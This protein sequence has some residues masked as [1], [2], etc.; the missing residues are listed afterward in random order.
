MGCC[1]ATAGSIPRPSAA[2]GALNRFDLIG[3]KLDYRTAPATALRCVRELRAA[4]R[5]GDVRIV[6]F[7]GDDDPNV[8][9]PALIE[10]VDGYVKKHVFADP[11]AYARTYRGKSNLTDHLVRTQ[12]L[13]LE[14][15]AVQTS[16]PL[17]AGAVGKI[18]LGWNIALDDK[19]HDLYRGL[20][21]PRLDGRTVDIA[22]RAYVPPTLWT[23][24]LR[25]PVVEQ[26]ERLATEL[27]VLAPRDR[28]DQARYYR[29]MLDAKLCVSPFGYGEICW[30]DFEAILCGS[31]LVK[32]DMGH[33]RTLPDVFIA[34][35]TYLPVRWD[36]AD[37]GEQCRRLLADDARRQ[38]MA[39]RARAALCEA[40]SGPWFVARFGD[41]L[42]SLARGPR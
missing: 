31:V 3:L 20:P 22:S 24:G 18:W 7:D 5:S 26:L 4:S 10:A 9:W 29:E 30:R 41:L 23:H 2:W 33:V 15:H 27:R 19:I 28:V 34:G 21:M 13:T 38:A 1:C 16:G 37:L 6:Y 11:A 39:R 8:Q 32:P 36:Y 35:E 14:G 17:T 40:L 42:A 25:A 12:G